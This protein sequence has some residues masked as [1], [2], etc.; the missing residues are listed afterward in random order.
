MKHKLK[1]FSK[2]PLIALYLMSAIVAYTPVLADSES[3]VTVC[4]LDSGCNMEDITGWNYLEGNNNLSD[5]SGHGTGVCEILLEKAPDANLVML[6]CFDGESENQTDDNTI[7]QAIYD[8]VDKYHA[9]ILN[10]SWTLN[11][12]SNLLHEA[13]QYASENGV[14]ILAAAG[15]LSFQTPSGSQ[16]YPAAWEEVIGV[17]GADLDE[18]GNPISSLW[19]LGGEAV[20]VSANGSYEDQKGSSYAVPRVS[21]AVAGYLLENPGVTQEK[22]LDYLKINRMISLFIVKINWNGIGIPFITNYRKSSSFFIF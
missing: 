12:D 5:N 6:K 11:R 14:L 16:V 19:Y 10:M 15:N 1:N 2:L 20:Y 17:A 13:I 4:I 7:I 3:Q 9:D 18:N 22:V 8:S 21:A